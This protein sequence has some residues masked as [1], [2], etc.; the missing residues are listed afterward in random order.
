MSDLQHGSKVIAG[1]VAI[2]SASLKK[3]W[4]LQCDVVLADM[5]NDFYLAKFHSMDDYQVVLEGGLW[6]VAD[7][8]LSVMKWR[9]N[10]DPFVASID[11]ATVWVRISLL[12]VEYYDQLIL[13]R[14]GNKLGKTMRV[15]KSTEASTRAKYARI[16]VEVDLRKPLISKFRLKCRIWK[17]EYEGLHLVCFGYRTYGHRRENCPA[18]QQVMPT[19]QNIDEQVP[20]LV[21]A[22]LLQEDLGI[23]PEIVESYGAWMLVQKPQRRH[24]RASD[25]GGKP[26]SRGG[27]DND[28]QGA[29]GDCRHDGL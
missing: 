24:L 4:K 17:V 16:S 3:Q 5:G 25:S 27:R 26:S 29:S 6:M 28:H 20:E 13:T 12:P 9:P 23:R 1:S 21:V 10:F 19:Q 22:P 8:M 11:K 18:E 14:I 15:D 2:D 7:H